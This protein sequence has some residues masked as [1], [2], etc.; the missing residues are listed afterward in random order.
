LRHLCSKPYWIPSEAF[1]KDMDFL[2][3]EN[4]KLLIDNRI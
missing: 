1:V 3:Y 4:C 2:L